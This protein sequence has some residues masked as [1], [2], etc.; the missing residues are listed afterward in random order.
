[1]FFVAKVA[2]VN[3]VPT[4]NDVEDSHKKHKKKEGRNQTSIVLIS[5]FVFFVFFV[6]K[7][8]WLVLRHQ[9]DDVR[10]LAS[11]ERKVRYPVQQ[12]A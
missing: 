6:A 1:V 12:R 4:A 7:F 9:S 3:G 2:V 10:H 5:I 11:M 8:L